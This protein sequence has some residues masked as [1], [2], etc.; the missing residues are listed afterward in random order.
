MDDTTVPSKNIT[1]VKNHPFVGIDLNLI[2]VFLVLF[3]ECNLTRAARI[4]NVSQ[5]AVSG[6]LAK[7]RAALGDELF[8]RTRYGVTPTERATQIAKAL[9]P[10][11]EAIRE[12]LQS[13]PE[14]GIEYNVVIPHGRD[15]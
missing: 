6:S 5:P 15:A 7:L 14:H 4:L 2:V 11:I 1:L 13:T 3:Q 9:K 12:V 10:A 8:K